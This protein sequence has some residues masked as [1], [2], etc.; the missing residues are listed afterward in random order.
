MD[1]TEILRALPASLEWMV[2]FR[3]SGIRSFAEDT[4]MKAMFFLPRPFDLASFSHVILTPAARY[5][6]TKD[7]SCLY[8]L[9]DD[10]LQS[11]PRPEISLYDRY[12]DL[13]SA[14]PPDEAHCLGFGRK[15]ELPPVVLHLV[16]E[17]E[18]GQ[19]KAIFHRR[20]SQDHYELLE[21]AGVEYQGGHGAE[22]GFVALFRNRLTTHIQ[23]A[24]LAGYGRTGNCNQFFLNHGE[25]DRNV[26]AGLIQASETRTAWAREMGIAAAGELARKACEASLAMTCQPPPPQKRVAYGDLVPLGFLLKAL[27]RTSRPT[28]AATADQ[29]RDRIMAGRQ[30]VLWPFHT[31]RL[32]TATDSVLILQ[33]LPERESIEALELFSDGYG[34]YYPQLWSETKEPGRM[35]MDEANKHWRQPDF[36]TTCLVRGLRASAG[37]PSSTPLGYL[38][39]CFESRSG[40]Y[41]ANPYLVDWAM[42]MAIQG[43][44]EAAEMKR[45]LQSEILAGMNDD[46]SFGTFD[47]ALSASFAILALAALG[48]RGRLLRLAQLRLAEMMDSRSGLWPECVPF[49]STF[50]AE[51]TLSPA[52]RRLENAPGACPSF[53]PL[54][55]GSPPQSGEGQAVS[56]AGNEQ[57]GSQILDVGGSRHELSLYFDTYRI[58]ATA[59]AVLALS[60]PC[61]PERRDLELRIAGSAHPRYRCRSHAEYIARFALP[62]YMGVAPASLRSASGRLCRP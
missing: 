16:I 19:A 31:G 54:G 58:I 47:P 42:A 38:E 41:F 15:A 5:L 40:L 13:L 34:G 61:I 4:Q 17:G 26:E 11:S 25:I 57:N 39:D 50:I 7:G 12:S 28:I 45:R 56:V 59:V 21:A 3:L 14:F 2:L 36:A 60:E 35:V 6:A 9:N 46:Y 24:S 10:R 8:K 52:P 32:V 27:K 44:G 43:D 49:F 53:A 37:L 29:L 22:A 62:P 51:E 1:V 23:A 48:C 20:P 55:T 33:G 30:G 18:Y